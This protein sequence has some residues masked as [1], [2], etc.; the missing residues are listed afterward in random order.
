MKKRRQIW[1]FSP[2]FQTLLFF[3]LLILSSCNKKIVQNLEKKSKQTLKLQDNSFITSDGAV[4]SYSDNNVANKPV[5]FF[6]HGYLSSRLGMFSLAKKIDDGNYRLIIV[7]VPGF[8]KSSKD[9]KANYKITEQAKRMN[10]LIKHLKLKDVHL[11]GTSMGG[12]ISIAVNATNERIKSN[13]LIAPLGMPL[14]TQELPGIFEY[15]IETG[16]LAF[17]IDNP[18][19]K[20]KTKTLIKNVTNLPYFLIPPFVKKHLKD[21]FQKGREATN[22]VGLDILY[23][24]KSV[25]NLIENNE[26][27]TSIKDL[28]SIYKNSYSQENLVTLLNKV[29]KYHKA[30]SVDQIGNSYE[31][32]TSCL[33][34]IKNPVLVYW[35]NKDNIIHYKT[36]ESMKPHLNNAKF[37]IF[38]NGSH[39][40][41]VTKSKI[42]SKEIKELISSIIIN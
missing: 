7:D 18:Y 38:K 4:I 16:K 40:I 23:D 24:T 12:A 37:K 1:V 26:R 6:I 19:S 17:V 28:I 36:T 34:K 5:I 33:E 20:E 15:F 42:I 27:F 14:Y 29:N 39:G 8:G 13:T 35:G 10:E 11:V 22:K 31:D 3:F 30:K 25:V 21:E 9:P 2:S 41:A 32:L